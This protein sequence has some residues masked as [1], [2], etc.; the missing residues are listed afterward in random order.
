MN[1][2]PDPHLGDLEL[3]R[4]FIGE[5]SDECT[6]DHL[7]DCEL[8]RGRIHKLVEEE[9]RFSKQIPY[10]RFAQ[11]VEEKLRQQAGGS[12]SGGLARLRWV[13]P[14][15][16]TAASIAVLVAVGMQG[17]FGKDAQA[18]VAAISAGSG[19]RTKGGAQVDLYVGRE[20]AASR[21]A[22]S[23]EILSEHDRVRIAY[24][25]GG[26]RYLAIISIDQSGRISALYPIEGE[27][28]PVDPSDRQTRVLPDSLSFDGEG[29][30]RVVILFS[31][32]PLLMGEIQRAAHEA[33]LAA[34]GD[35]EKLGKLTLPVEG[36]LEEIS[37]T[38]IK[39]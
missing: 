13:A 20:G 11:G 19:S 39:P 18:P 31:D 23:R 35:L 26:W 3:R 28:L 7:E 38:L 16:A 29:L 2:A 25:P 36:G 12:S 34:R 8:C 10:A 9:G 27:S 32:A 33:F 15:F 6:T 24:R 5:R 14:L 4:Y 37:R 17:S 1:T 22:A 30:E 21:V